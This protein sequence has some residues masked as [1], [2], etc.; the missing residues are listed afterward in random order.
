MQSR[1]VGRVGAILSKR[2]DP[3]RATGMVHTSVSSDWEVSDSTASNGADP[4]GANANRTQ[5]RVVR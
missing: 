2:I 5:F 3:R 4:F 1:V